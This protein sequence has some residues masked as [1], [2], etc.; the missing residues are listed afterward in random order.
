MENDSVKQPIKKEGHAASAQIVN[1]HHN[2]KY[3]SCSAT[4]LIGKVSLKR[5]WRKMRI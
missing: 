4:L 1:V 3:I 5:A 2:A